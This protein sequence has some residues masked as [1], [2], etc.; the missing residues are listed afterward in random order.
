MGLFFGLILLLTLV[1]P[2]ISVDRF[3]LL[4]VPN[5]VVPVLVVINVLFI[6]YWALQRNRL[7]W[8][9]CLVQLMV[10]V[11][12]GSFYQLSAKDAST[13]S[14]IKVLSFN[15]RSF[16]D[17]EVMDLPDVDKKILEF[18]DEVNPDI[19]CF[20]EFY[21][22]KQYDGNFSNYPYH[23]VDFDEERP[24]DKVVQAIFSKFPIVHKRTFDF[25]KS[26]N[27]AIAVDVVVKHDTLRIYNV[28]L[29]SF[30]II[31]NLTTLQ[32]EESLGLLK[33][34]S[35]AFRKQ[36]EQA[37]LIQDD[38][39]LNT[40]PKLI[41]ADLNNTQFSKVYKTMTKDFNDSFLEAGSGF[42]RTFKLFGMPMRIDYIFADENFEVTSHT[43]YDIELSDHYPVMATIRRLSQE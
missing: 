32:E 21:H 20:Q 35:K 16:N 12:F 9:G 17:N 26:G 1:V 7:F 5:L 42:G 6:L 2:Y 39:E 13:E 14:D 41:C 29:Q 33:R 11:V 3:P 18:V 38:I 25:P 43:N 31:P 28:H 24:R 37:K 34:V 30:S 23:F 36:Y 10:F 8:F 22:L 40:Y 27:N 19:I 4:S 15:A